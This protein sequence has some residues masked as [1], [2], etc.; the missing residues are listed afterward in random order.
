MA[1][2]CIR[3]LLMLL[4]CVALHSWANPK[5]SMASDAVG[6]RRCTDV[7]PAVAESEQELIRIFAMAYR[8]RDFEL[9]QTLFAH[10]DEHGV[11]YTFFLVG[12]TE[13]GDTQWGYDEE[14]RIHRRMF[15]PGT[16]PEGEALRRAL[17]VKH[18]FLQ[19]HQ[20]RG[21]KERYDLY[22][23]DANLEGLD[24]KRWRATDAEYSTHLRVTT[25]G[26][27]T[28]SVLGTA[29]FVVIEDLHKQLGEPDKFL[30]FHW[31]DEGRS[32]NVR[33]RAAK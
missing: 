14:M 20:Q 27:G 13:D 21:F 25:Q 16:L 31:V 7:L 19:L 8:S 4:F 18:I 10:E 30:I 11:P 6:E 23:S 24:R 1:S 2:K 9:Y 17:W 28:F 15:A 32:H 3:A 22:R 5:E 33:Q 12:R 29:N 26:A